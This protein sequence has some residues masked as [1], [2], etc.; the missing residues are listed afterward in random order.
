MILGPKQADPF[1][2]LDEVDLHIRGLGVANMPYKILEDQFG[3][4]APK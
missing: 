2:P 4:I 3:S 1:K